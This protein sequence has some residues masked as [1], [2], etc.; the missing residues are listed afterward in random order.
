MKK[1]IQMIKLI[2]D[3]QDGD[4]L[5]TEDELEEV[6]SIAINCSKQEELTTILEEHKKKMIS[7][8]NKKE[9][10]KTIEGVSKKQLL[11]EV[12]KE[13]EKVREKN[14]KR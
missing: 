4:E 1:I 14:E 13:A 6:Y 11:E 10:L 2:E 5:F 3:C 8:A 9:G 12:Q 7:I